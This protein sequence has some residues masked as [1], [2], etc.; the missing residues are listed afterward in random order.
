MRPRPASEGKKRET[1]AMDLG[2]EPCRRAP[3]TYH[4]GVRSGTDHLMP[5]I[6]CKLYVGCPHDK[7]P[8][9]AVPVYV[10]PRNN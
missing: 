10:C 5:P 7:R 8:S 4:T 9:G 1:T 6:L 2:P 3:W